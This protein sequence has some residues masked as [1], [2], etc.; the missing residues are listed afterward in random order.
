MSVD[1]KI[2]PERHG[3]RWTKEED[4]QI[5]QEIKDN[6]DLLQISENHKRTL[7]SVKCRVI[8]HLYDMKKTPEELILIY[9]KIPLNELVLG[10]KDITPIK[11]IVITDDILLDLNEK[12]KEAVN[13]VYNNDNIFL[14]GSPGTGKSFTLGRIV[15]ALK[16]I[17]KKYGI[18]ALTGT[19]AILINA[20]TLHSF[21]GIGIGKDKVANIIY[22]LQTKNPSKYKTLFNLQTLIIDEISMMDDKLFEKV[23]EL[24]C[25]I[26]KNSLPFG[27]IQLILV[28]D[29]CQLAPVEGDYCFTSPLWSSTNLKTIE[30]LELVRQKGDIDFQN[31]LQEI[32]KGKCTKKTFNKLLALQNT[33]F[34]ND[35][36]PT[37][38][39]PINVD[40]D[41]INIKEFNKLCKNPDSQIFTYK[42]EPYNKNIKNELYDVSLVKNAQIMIIRNIDQ[43]NGLVNGT[44]GIITDLTENYIIIKD[45]NNMI[46]KI[47]YFTDLDQDN[48]LLV[49]FMPVKLAYAISIHKSQGSTLDAVE[50]DAGGNIFAC[51]QLYTALSRAKSLSS[52]KILDLHP[53]SFIT[54]KKLKF[55]YN[56]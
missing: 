52:I 43:Q 12:Q 4:E 48:K 32:R 51:G 44:R 37:K 19:A 29:F 41:N 7:I 14:T 5:L 38:L 55:F 30:L 13:S 17:K 9:N 35:I 18:T 1:K 8:Q 34:E 22:K 16:L 54:S 10:L 3:L 24:F 2:N 31:M 6:I 28:G 26:K 49:K 25:E 39:F 40:V 56:L 47:D 21:L 50:I 15:K 33:K 27:G 45:I 36:K 20:Q 23:S 53:E 46:Y 11:K 42:S